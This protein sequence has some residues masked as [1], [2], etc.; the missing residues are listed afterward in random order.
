M[1]PFNE[2]TSTEIKALSKEEFDNISPFDKH[3]CYDCIYLKGFINI[4]CTNKKA[5]QY[6]NTAIPGVI[7]CIFWAPNWDWIE[8]KYRTPENGYVSPVKKV[9]NLLKNIF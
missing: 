5:I 7:K 1:K 8:D 9:K 2:M 4:W 6:R 3:S